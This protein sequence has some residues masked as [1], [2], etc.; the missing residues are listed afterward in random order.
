[1]ELKNGTRLRSQVDDTQVIV[2]KGLPGDIDLGSGGHPMIE[3]SDAPTEGLSVKDGFDGGAL[4]GKRYTDASGDL[5]LLV[6]KGGGASLS[7]DGVVL[8]VKQAKA[9][10]AS[11]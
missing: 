3:L 6:S 5:E 9:L 1:M 8:E 7:L 2:V 11:D 4:L 10:P